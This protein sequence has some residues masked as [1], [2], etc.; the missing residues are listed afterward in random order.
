MTIA[1]RVASVPWASVDAELDE[2]G[3]GRLG[4][5]LTPKECAALSAL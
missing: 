4:R 5:I 1:E 3:V 2:Y